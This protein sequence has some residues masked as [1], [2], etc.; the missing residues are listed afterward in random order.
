MSGALAPAVMSPVI[1]N[2]EMHF[3]KWL[4][5]KNIP[6]GLK[7]LRLLLNSYGTTEVVPFQ[8][9]TSITGC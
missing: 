2:S 1:R 3:C 8:N 4:M 9:S 6:Q 7:A 5:L